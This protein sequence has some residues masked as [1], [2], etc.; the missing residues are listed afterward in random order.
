M[1]MST[2]ER[3]RFWR[4]VRRRRPVNR[5]FLY[6][7]LVAACAL[8]CCNNKSVSG[9][10]GDDANTDASTE[11]SAGDISAR[12]MEASGVVHQRVGGGGRS[13]G[14]HR[15]GPAGAIRRRLRDRF[16]RR[17]YGATSSLPITHPTS[18]APDLFP[19]PRNRRQSCKAGHFHLHSSHSRLQTKGVGGRS[20]SHQ[21]SPARVGPNRPRDSHLAPHRSIRSAALPRRIQ[22]RNSSEYLFELIIFLISRRLLVSSSI[23]RNSLL[24][25]NSIR[26]LKIKCLDNL[27]SDGL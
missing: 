15:D 23:H 6:I 14:G 1:Y 19:G 25:R 3:C 13:A 2:D 8:H 7:S 17:Q 5:I 16:G 26:L 18:Y 22:S 9:S 11:A 24:T 12:G 21:L 10:A 20:H 4:S 27:Q